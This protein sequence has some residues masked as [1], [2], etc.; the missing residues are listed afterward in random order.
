MVNSTQMTRQTSSISLASIAHHRHGLGQIN[1]QTMLRQEEGLETLHELPTPTS[2]MSVC[3]VISP[4]GGKIGAVC[5]P[6]GVSTVV[7]GG[8]ADAVGGRIIRSSGAYPSS[9]WTEASWLRSGI[10]SEVKLKRPSVFSCPDTDRPVNMMPLMNDFCSLPMLSRTGA[11]VTSSR[12]S[13][14]R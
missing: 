2:K 13:K 12:S 11:V 14:R 8:Q 6:V 5:G 10:S 1:V 9:S 4:A 3:S 7:S